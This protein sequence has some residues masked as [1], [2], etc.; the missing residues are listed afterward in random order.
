MRCWRFLWLRRSGLGV[1]NVSGA[2]VYRAWGS[3]CEGIGH[4]APG[5]RLARVPG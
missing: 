3:G 1:G 2:T 5:T 4:R